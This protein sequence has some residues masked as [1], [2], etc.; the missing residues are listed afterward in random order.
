MP[1]LAGQPLPGFEGI[2]IDLG[3]EQ[4]KGRRVLVCFFDWEQRPSRHDVMQLAEQAE[5]L[6]EKGVSIVAVQAA[7]TDAAALQKWA[8]DTGIPFPVG[9][10][11]GGKDEIFS[12]WSIPSLPWLILTDRNHVVT[13]EGFALGELDKAIGELSDGR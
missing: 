1:P 3:P 6:K 11:Q 5:A 12:A 13:Q 4:M 8:A 7:K 9:A 10:I 2:K